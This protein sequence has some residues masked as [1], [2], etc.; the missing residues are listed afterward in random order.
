MYSQIPN[1]SQVSWKEFNG[2]VCTGKVICQIN[3]NRGNYSGYVEIDVDQKFYHVACH[4][5]Y[6]MHSGTVSRDVEMHDVAQIQH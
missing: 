6:E 2:K 4:G 3:D 1:G 5:N